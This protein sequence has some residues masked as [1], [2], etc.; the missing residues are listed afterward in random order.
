[1]RCV[2]TNAG[3]AHFEERLEWE[4][5]AADLHG[6]PGADVMVDACGC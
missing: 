3:V 2:N 1:M 5:D 6:D 4:I